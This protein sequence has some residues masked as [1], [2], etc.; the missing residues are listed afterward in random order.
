[1]GF[2]KILLSDFIDKFLTYVYHDYLIVKNE[3]MYET[4]CQRLLESN[5]AEVTKNDR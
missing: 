5:K 2:Q 3:K 4:M 1:M